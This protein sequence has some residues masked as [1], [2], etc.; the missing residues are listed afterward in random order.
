MTV[1]DDKENEY[2]HLQPQLGGDDK[3]DKISPSIKKGPDVYTAEGVGV[4]YP[5]MLDVWYS[6][7]KPPIPIPGGSI[8]DLEHFLSQPAPDL[9]K[10]GIALTWLE[11]KGKGER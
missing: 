9:V 4:Y 10:V 7:G 8:K 3:D 11:R 5:K 1:G 6:R 2:R